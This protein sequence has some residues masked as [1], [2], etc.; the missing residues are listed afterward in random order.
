M[1]KIYAQDASD[2]KLFG[3]SVSIYDDNAFI[4]AVGDSDVGYETGV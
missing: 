3:W 1:S 2:N 4:G